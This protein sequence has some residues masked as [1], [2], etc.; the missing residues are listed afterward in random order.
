[1]AITTSHTASVPQCV[2]IAPEHAE[3]SPLLSACLT[4]E[5]YSC[6]FAKD[7]REMLALAAQNRLSLIVLDGPMSDANDWD[8][9][10]RVRSVS[11]VPLLILSAR[12]GAC[13]IAQALTLGADDYV[14]KPFR[15][16]ELTAR[17]KALVRRAN[18]QPLAQMLS[19]GHITLNLS[20]R[21]VTLKGERVALTSSELRI[22][23]VLM[24]APGRVFSRKELLA[25]LYPTGGVVIERVIDVHVLKLRAKL[26]DDRAR[27]RY[28]L[29]ARGAGYRFADAS[30]GPDADTAPR[31]GL[32]QPDGRPVT[33]EPDSSPSSRNARSD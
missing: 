18:M 26:E 24:A 23:E 1:M 22:L 21:S 6:V 17:I 31:S 5:G 27:P 12:A 11:P 9:C 3:T 14:V 8:I 13:D 19:H 29:T 33:R 15:L 20:R 4:R 2:L 28:I 16:A 7:E 25:Y 32:D 10:R 30:D